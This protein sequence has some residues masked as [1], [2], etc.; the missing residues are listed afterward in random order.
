MIFISF[1]YPRL[2][3]SLVTKS[4]VGFAFFKTNKFELFKKIWL[5]LFRNW[6][7][8]EWSV[9]SHLCIFLTSYF[10]IFSIQGNECCSRNDVKFKTIQWMY[11][12]NKTLALAVQNFYCI[13]EKA[14]TFATEKVRHRQKNG[15]L[16]KFYYPCHQNQSV[17][18]IHPSCRIEGTD[19]VFFAANPWTIEI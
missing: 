13:V 10:Q 12:I 8:N 19:L 1:W 17:K 2:N 5:K 3:S 4:K 15:R 18:K 7:K 9:C 6:K 11:L 14:K 16:L